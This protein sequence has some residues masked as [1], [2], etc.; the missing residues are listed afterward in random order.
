MGDGDP[1]AERAARNDAA[2]RSA[3]RA[4]AEAA[5]QAEMAALPL[6]CECATESCTRIIRVAREHYLRARANPR[7][8]LTAPGHESEAEGFATIVEE[9]DG[10]VVVEKEER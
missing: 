5:E 8:F 9:Y 1:A 10:Y 4:I 3:N 7:W 6:I 2:F